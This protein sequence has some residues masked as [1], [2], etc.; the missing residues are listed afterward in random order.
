MPW[1]SD[2]ERRRFAQGR[3]EFVARRDTDDG[4]GPLY[5]AVSC[6]VCHEKPVPG[7]SA[8][9]YRN[10]FVAVMPSPTLGLTA[11]R[12][13]SVGPTARAPDISTLGLL[14]RNPMPLF[15]VGALAEVPDS[16]ILRNHDPNDRDG[17]GISGRVN[18]DRGFIGRLGSK[19]QSASLDDFTRGALLEHLG[20]TASAVPPATQANDAMLPR[21]ISTTDED[22]RGDP[23]LDNAAQRNLATFVRLLAAPM[24]DVGVEDHRGRPAFD[25]CDCAACHRD[26]LVGP[27]G[28]VPAFTDLLLHDLGPDLADGIAVGEASGSEFRTAPLWGVAASGPYLHDGRA[29][30]LE[31]AILSHDGE[32]ARSRR[33][34]E[35]LPAAERN[36]LI[37]FLAALGGGD[38]RNDG[39]LALDPPPSRPGELGGPLAGLSQ[40]DLRSFERGRVLF[41]RDFSIDAGLGP[42]FNGDSCR[43]C[44]FDGAIGGAGPR[45][46]DVLRAAVQTGD[47]T[48]VPAHNNVAMRHAIDLQRPSVADEIDWFERRQTPALFGLGLVDAIADEDILALADPDDRNHDG[49]RGRA[50]V[51]PDG[52]I[53]RFGW[54]ASVPTL[55][56]FV[57]LALADELGLTIAGAPAGFGREI[58][59][60]DVPD[61]ELTAAEVDDLIVFLTALGPPIAGE[62]GPGEGACAFMSVGCDGC[63]RPQFTTRT[64]VAFAP[65]AD[66]L[67]HDVLAPEDMVLVDPLAG[68]GFRTPPLWGVAHSAPYFHDGRAATLEEAIAAHAGEAEGARTRYE[69][70]PAATKAALIGYLRGL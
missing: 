69:Q 57:R 21:P 37:D 64:G 43:S 65:F 54:R 40:E 48:A 29:D 9:R 39:L 24:P 36:E 11:Q 15:G 23:E 35:R 67:L 14:S 27:F 46:V 53:G 41:D 12:Q 5:D 16:E 66:F 7:G 68:R 70:L 4:F 26:D 34:F 20:S 42:L 32:A 59:Q 1:A 30:T 2:D 61:P 52:S 17:D 3:T 56:D 63:H 62:D 51:L 38:F 47:A 50:N 10:T 22:S 49:I 31:Q 55:G 28:P 60:D 45:D 18:F 8:S 19:A 58:D 33:C 6:V 25:A 44:H 13:F